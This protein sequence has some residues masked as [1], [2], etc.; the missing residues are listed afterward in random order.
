VWKILQNKIQL[1]TTWKKRMWSCSSIPL[2][3]MWIQN[4]IQVTKWLLID[5]KRSII[6]ISHTFNQRVKRIKRIFFPPSS[7]LYSSIVTTWEVTKRF[8]MLNI[9]AMVWQSQPWGII[10]RQIVTLLLFRHFLLHLLMCQIRTS[11]R[12]IRKQI[13][14]LHCTKMNET[15]H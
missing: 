11:I 6:S 1:A 8:D 15:H 14:Y 2:R 4:K 3:Q 12:L 9:M 7:P 13:F 5:A 10:V